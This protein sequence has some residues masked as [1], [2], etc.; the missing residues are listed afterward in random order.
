[1]SMIPKGG[2]TIWGGLDW[3]PEEGCVPSK[4]RQRNNDTQLAR[5][6]VEGNL[7]SQSRNVNYGR[8]ISFGKDVAEAHSSDIERTVF[9]VRLRLR[10]PSFSR[11]RHTACFKIWILKISQSLCQ[12]PQN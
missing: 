10:I 1:M 11:C 3:S 6:N 5:Q 2:D 7:A 12:G 4:R 8:I 9:Q